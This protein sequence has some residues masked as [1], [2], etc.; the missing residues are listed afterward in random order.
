VVVWDGLNTHVSHAIAVALA[1]VAD[2]LKVD[3][4]VRSPN[5]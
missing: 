4:P 2:A 5:R 1:V 3:D